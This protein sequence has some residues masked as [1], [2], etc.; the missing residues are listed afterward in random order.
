MLRYAQHDNVEAPAPLPP[1]RG[2]VAL[3]PGPG[4]AAAGEGR[5]DPRWCGYDWR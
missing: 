4:S 1:Q 3:T 5:L 2:P